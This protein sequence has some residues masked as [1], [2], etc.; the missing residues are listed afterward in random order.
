MS[1][2]KFRSTKKVNGTDIDYANGF[3]IANTDKG[4]YVNLRNDSSYHEE[5]PDAEERLYDWAI[6]SGNL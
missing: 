6:E 2:Q 1:M 3:K 4:Y 5:L